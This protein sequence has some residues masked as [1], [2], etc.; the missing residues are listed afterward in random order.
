MRLVARRGPSADDGVWHGNCAIV[1]DG[2]SQQPSRSHRYEDH[3][4][5]APADS[6]PVANGG[7]IG[8][9]ERVFETVARRSY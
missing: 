1:A 7:G 6:G 3:R 8:A 9:S 2:Q 4:G 5:C